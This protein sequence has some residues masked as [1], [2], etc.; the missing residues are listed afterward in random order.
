MTFPWDY[1]EIQQLVQS[2]FVAAPK[3]L[4]SSPPRVERNLHD[5]PRRR[6]ERAS[7]RRM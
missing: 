5:G 4:S 1:P 6:R 3:A 2:F 7:N